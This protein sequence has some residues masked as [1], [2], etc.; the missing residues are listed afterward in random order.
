MNEIEEA[1]EE[2]APTSE[3][4][5]NGP[6]DGETL[7]EA[8]TAGYK[9]AQEK[10]ERELHQQRFNNEHNLSI[11]QKVADRIPELEMQI[12][13]QGQNL[14]HYTNEQLKLEAENARMREA[15]K[16]ISNMNPLND[17][18]LNSLRMIQIADEALAKEQNEN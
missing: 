12:K 1:F 5:K 10:Y 11:D 13:T 17:S 9:A 8:F 3:A 2:W 4:W 7:S 15:L 14:T 16:E 18:K 6:F